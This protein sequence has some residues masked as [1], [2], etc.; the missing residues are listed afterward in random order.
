MVHESYDMN[1]E[2]D[3]VALEASLIYRTNPQA[4][5]SVYGGIGMT[6]GLS[7]NANTSIDY[8]KSRGVSMNGNEPGYYPYPIYYSSQG[9][10]LS[11]TFRNKSS[12][13]QSFFFPLGVDFRI[14]RKNDFWKRLHLFYEMRPGLLFTFIPET[15]TVTEAFFQSTFGLRVEIK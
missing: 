4:R 14:A 2:T 15:R 1:Y 10:G 6:A 9:T 3:Q 5:W 7:I 8:W 12:F 13:A 11:E